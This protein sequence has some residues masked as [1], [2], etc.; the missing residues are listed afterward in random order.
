MSFPGGA[1]DMRGTTS[2]LCAW[3]AA[4]L[5]GKVLSPESLQAM[6]TPVTLNDGKLPTHLGR[7]GDRVETRYG[8]GVGLDIIGGHRTVSHGG[9]IQGFAAYLETLP[10]DDV[11]FAQMINTEGGSFAPPAFRAA[12]S[13]LNRAIRAAALAA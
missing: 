13:A 12:P 10:D 5:G 8:F 7:N 9:E 6:L 4:L 2:D 11:T 1:G 3:H